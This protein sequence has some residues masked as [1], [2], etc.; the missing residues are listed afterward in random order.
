[1]SYSYVQSFTRKFAIAL[2]ASWQSSRAA[3]RR[4]QPR[5]GFC[6]RDTCDRT[7]SKTPNL[8]EIANFRKAFAMPCDHAIHLPRT[9]HIKQLQ[10]PQQQP[11]SSCSSLSSSCRC[12]SMHHMQGSQFLSDALNTAGGPL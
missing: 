8:R 2:G 9:D 5:S 1:M 11:S 6:H 7:P 12:R 3:L 4:R 10:Q